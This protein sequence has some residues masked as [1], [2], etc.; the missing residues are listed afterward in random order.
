MT[1]GGDRRDDDRDGPRDG[2]RPGENGSGEDDAEKDDAEK[3]DAEKDDPGDVGWA[4]PDDTDDADVDP[5]GGG[6]DDLT[7]L[8]PDDV[9]VDVDPG[10][11]AGSDDP[12]ADLD[13]GAGAGSGDPCADLDDSGEEASETDPFEEMEVGELDEDV[14]EALSEEGAEAG[15]A[16]AAESGVGATPVEEEGDRTDHIVD[17]RQYC[18]SCPYFSDP[19]TVAC[20]HEGTE[21]V[22]VADED[23]FRVR[24]CP[25]IAE[26]GPQFDRG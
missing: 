14:W 23:H 12:F 4:A 9:E 20:E 25:M 3:D 10:I 1:D 15:P 24:G 6:D 18:Q 2:G 19:P 22:E 17:K 7:E 16:S 5:A 8:D 13:A 21:I 26:E 11:D